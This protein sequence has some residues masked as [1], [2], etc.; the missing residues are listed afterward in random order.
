MIGAEADI[1]NGFAAY[2]RG[3]LA[4]ARSILERVPHHQAWHALGLVERASGQY[5]RAIAWL[6]KAEKSDPRNP[7]IA[8]NQ[9]RVALDAGDPIYAERAFRRALTLRA[10]WLPALT[11]L[12]RSLNDQEKW[13]EAHPIWTKAVE[14]NPNER[15]SRYNAAMAALEI[16]HVEFAEAEFDRLIK[17]GLT[18]PAVFF[19]RGRARVE[20]SD[21]T[22]GLSDFRVSWNKQKTAHAMKNLANTLWM[23]GDQK[24]FYDL[25][26]D[27]PDALGGLKMFLLS[28][29]GETELALRIWDELPEQFQNDPDT[30]TA[31]SN[32]HRM[33]G[34]QAEALTAAS[35]AHALRPLQAN[36]DDSLISAQLMAGD[37]ASALKTVADWRAR[38][39]L[40]QSWIAHEATAL[41]LANAPEYTELADPDRFI[42][43][44]ELE[45]PEGFASIQA[46][47]DALIEAIAPMQSFDQRPLDQTLRAGTQTARDLVHV[48]NDTI[49]SFL[50]TLDAPIRAYLNAIGFDADHPFLGRNTG[51]YRFNGCWSVTLKGGGHHVNHVHPRGWI[52]SAYYARVPDE[53][54]RGDSKAGWIKFGEPPFKT[55]PILDPVKWV[56]PKSGLL[57]LFPSY[58]W[59]G[60][61]PILDASER[62]TVP[63]DLV[64]A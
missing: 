44:F 53:T 19:M 27:A 32:I 36:I 61:H 48:Q 64:P 54:L 38:E 58:F 33:R 6:E 13:R 55:N 63:F 56:Q 59:H 31:K 30:L 40:V 49:Q 28:K 50:R 8:N 60:T 35:K 34:E 41:R 18:D 2:K 3:D 42:Q 9:G 10:N 12:G 46:F 5:A 14:L 7:E 62:V 16:G 29:S 1:A 37:H 22:E 15:V 52:S 26:R 11:G 57:V 45:T 43:A 20:L 24:G 4:A 21:L 39:P 25:V 23:T 17:S 47:N 51:N